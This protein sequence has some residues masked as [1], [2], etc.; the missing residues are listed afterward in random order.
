MLSLR[1]YGEDICR[2]TVF[3]RDA[4]AAGDGQA[5]SEEVQAVE[6]ESAEPTEEFSL[7]AS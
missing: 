2:I 6:T 7:N 4:E 3:K 1:T 5:V